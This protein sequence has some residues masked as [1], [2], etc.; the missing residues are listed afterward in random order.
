M[1]AGHFLY[2]QPLP[3]LES[4]LT[5]PAETPAQVTS[6]PTGYNEASEPTQALNCEGRDPVTDLP[7]RIIDTLAEYHLGSEPN[8]SVDSEEHGPVED[9]DFLPQQACP[10][11]L[12][13]PLELRQQIYGYLLPYNDK[14]IFQT[15]QPHSAIPNF[16]Y[17]YAGLNDHGYYHHDGYWSL[18]AYTD[19]MRVNKQLH[20]YVDI[21]GSHPV[22]GVQAG[23]SAYFLFPRNVL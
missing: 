21:G 6:P 12:Q 22:S 4:G 5:K 7:D 2:Q 11:L 13:L 16:G 14:H 18:N 17:R 23:A 19:I 9:E 1:A 20:W 3:S 15:R 10:G 8:L